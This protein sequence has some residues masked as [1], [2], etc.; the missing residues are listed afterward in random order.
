[1]VRHAVGY[2]LRWRK[3]E[4]G[5]P[6]CLLMRVEI[7]GW[8]GQI[9]LDAEDAKLIAEMCMSYA[10]GKMPERKLQGCALN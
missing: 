9:P 10:E 3:S 4:A 6:P 2:E 8:W 1:M 7:Q 5:M